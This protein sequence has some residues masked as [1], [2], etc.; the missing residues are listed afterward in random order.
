MDKD[1]FLLESISVY[2]AEHLS[3]TKSVC[4]VGVI[5]LKLILAIN[6]YRL[7]TSYSKHV[8]IKL[9]KKSTIILRLAPD[10]LLKHL[11]SNEKRNFESL[12]L[13]VMP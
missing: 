12:D 9:N 7:N 4:L 8:I 5:F 1:C 11:D 3:F 6:W 13:F 10:Q 2:L